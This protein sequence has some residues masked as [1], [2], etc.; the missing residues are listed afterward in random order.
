MTDK[1]T[2]PA[3]DWSPQS[4]NGVPRSGWTRIRRVARWHRPYTLVLF[5]LDYVAVIAADLT[6]VTQLDRAKA[7]FTDDLELFRLII[8]LFLPLSWVIVLW[9]NGAYDRRYLGVGTDEFRRVVRASLIMA[10][11]VSFMAFSFKAELSRLS[12]ATALL[13]AAIYIT[14]L[15]YFARK[16]LHLMRHRGHASHRVLL[17]GTFGDAL[18]VHTA[19]SRNPSAGM[20]PVGI[21]VADGYPAARTAKAP[22]PVYSGRDV[23]SL[24]NEVHADTVAVCGAASRRGRP[25]PAGLA[26]GGHRHRP[27]GGPAVDRH[28]GP[29]GARPAGGGAAAALR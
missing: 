14:V 20:V 16:V 19:V 2:D 24:V 15:R 1:T 18:G 4:N 27:G 5:L 7:G 23:V 12:V 28:R 6:A 3:D 13:G 25:A 26:V 21:L 10:A 9:A 8:F 22:I 29:P 17:V 11:I